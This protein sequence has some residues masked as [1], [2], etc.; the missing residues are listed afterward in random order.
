VGL[1]FERIPEKNEKIDLSIG[2]LGAEMSK[3]MTS[4]SGI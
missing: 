1:R 2:Y 3:D 4:F